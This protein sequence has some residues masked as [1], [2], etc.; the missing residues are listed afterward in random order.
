MS[1]S[2]CVGVTRL[3][4]HCKQLTNLTPMKYLFI[5]RLEMAKKMMEEVHEF[6]ISEIAYKCGFSSS[7]YF[8]TIF[9]KYEKCTPKEYQ[10]KYVFSQHN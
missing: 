1:K 7:Q 6:N 9:K 3:T 8:S 10:V 4:H 2:A 5:R